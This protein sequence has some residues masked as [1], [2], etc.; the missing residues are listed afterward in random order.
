VYKA[1]PQNFSEEKPPLV[2]N[3]L[4]PLD[5]TPRLNPTWV[6]NWQ[7]QVEEESSANN[8]TPIP[9][10]YSPL[11][12]RAIG[13]VKG[14]YFPTQSD[15]IRGILVLEDGAIAPVHFLASSISF[16]KKHMELLNAPQFWIVYPKTQLEAPHLHFA[17]KGV[18]S[19]SEEENSEAL[20]VQKDHF[21]VRGL[22][23]YIDSKAGT[24]VVRIYHNDSVGSSTTHQQNFFLLTIQGTV[25]S[26]AFGQFADLDVCREGDKLILKNAS[27]VGQLVQPK[28]QKRKKKRSHRQNKAR[29]NE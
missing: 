26:E 21:S 13:V 18:K 17:V 19:V 15:L 8:S 5:Q 2:L 3:K 16:L 23:T 25:N 6:E 29:A 7:I 9:P 28:K 10:P 14:Q 1:Q 22:V 12:Y 20:T 11:Q 24:F 27:F 4:Q